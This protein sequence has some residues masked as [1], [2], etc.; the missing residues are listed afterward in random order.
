MKDIIF[1]KDGY[2]ASYWLYAN[3]AMLL[4]GPSGKMQTGWQEVWGQMLSGTDGA[5]QTYWSVIDGKYYW[6]GSDGADADRYWA[7]KYGV[8]IIILETME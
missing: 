6:L 1:D 5:M 2:R 4:A 7:R 8:N 3:R